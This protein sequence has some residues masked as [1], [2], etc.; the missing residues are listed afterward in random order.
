[1]SLEEIGQELGITSERVRQIQESALSKL[2]RRCMPELKAMRE[3]AIEMRRNGGHS[4]CGVI[5]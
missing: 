2:R 5:R 4:T 3:M 1:M